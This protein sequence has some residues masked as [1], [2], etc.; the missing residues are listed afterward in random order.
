MYPNL[1][2]YVYKNSK[3]NTPQNKTLRNEA[4]SHLRSDPSISF[5]KDEKQ[6]S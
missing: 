1:T 3:T 4:Q 6:V 5:K 2:H